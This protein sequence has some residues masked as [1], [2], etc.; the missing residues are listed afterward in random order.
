MQL[1]NK[2][3]H[4]GLESQ[5]LRSCFCRTGLDAIPIPYGGSVITAST[6]GSVGNISKQ[7]PQYSVQSPITTFSVIDDNQD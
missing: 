6:L 4:T 5:V 2:F 3:P 7:S 1:R